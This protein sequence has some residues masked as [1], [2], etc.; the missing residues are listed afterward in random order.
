M[1][2]EK[3]GELSPE[4]WEKIRKGME[5]EMQK[6]TGS[7]YATLTLEE[8][9]RKLAAEQVEANLEAAKEIQKQPEIFG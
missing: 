8:A 7:R 2:M 6:G 1:S 9:K 4:Q 3:P 5:E